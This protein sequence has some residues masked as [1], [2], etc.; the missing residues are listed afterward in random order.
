MDSERLVKT[1]FHLHT[2]ETSPCGMVPGREIIRVLAA[3]GYGG[4]IVT[5][6]Y[7]P[8][9]FDRPETRGLFLEGY[10]AAREAG[11]ALGVTVLPGMEFRFADADN[12][13]LVYGMQE[14]DFAELPAGLSGYP[15]A[16]FSAYCRA[17][18]WL[19][20]QAHPFR[21]W[22]SVQDPSYLDGVEVFNGNPR[23]LNHNGQALIFARAH[24]LLGVAG[25]DV[26]QLEDVRPDGLEV[27]QSLLTPK[28]IVR[29]LR[30]LPASSAV[31]G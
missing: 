21:P 9:A 14:A 5:D 6:H 2:A 18:G 13:F 20:Y 22:C 26:H 25:G 3:A 24:N 4:V 28:G 12:D 8:G 17:H 31:F 7:L 11:A 15:L 23:Q 16:D 19:V 27:P 1:E 30:A 29:F 10:R